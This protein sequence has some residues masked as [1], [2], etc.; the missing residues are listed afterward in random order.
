M[1]FHDARDQLSDLEKDTL[2]YAK[3][4]KADKLAECLAKGASPNQAELLFYAAKRGHAEVVDL[5]L[6]HGADPNAKNQ[7]NDCNLGPLH[8]A[9]DS[10][11]LRIVK[12]LLAHGADPNAKNTEYGTALSY[13][14]EKGHLELAELL[15]SV[16]DT[17]ITYKVDE[18]LA[19]TNPEAAYFRLHWRIREDW[20][21]GYSPAEERFLSLGAF[22]TFGVSNGIT[23]MLWQGGLW[24]IQ[25]GIELFE[26]I[27]EPVYGQFLRDGL[28]I[29]HEECQVKDLEMTP[30]LG[31]HLRFDELA[32]SKLNDLSSKLWATSD[33]GLEDGRLYRKTM[34][35]VAKNRHLYE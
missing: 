27:D 9:A 13:A 35:Y 4:G 8:Y 7:K 30:D 22:F 6:T 10:G 11:H 19:I 24:S 25:S 16:T 34:E 23:D 5:L 1:L 15:R 18:A 17:R 12:M 29:I 14:M 26:A 2:L 32:K 33:T 31:Q 20:H 21:R 3:T 28:A